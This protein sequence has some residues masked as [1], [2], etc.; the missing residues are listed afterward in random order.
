MSGAGSFSVGER[1]EG[2]LNPWAALTAWAD[3]GL[4][5]PVIDQVFPLSEIVAAARRQETKRARGKII[6]RIE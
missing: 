4:L 2:S 1:V 5:K 6:I 3:Q